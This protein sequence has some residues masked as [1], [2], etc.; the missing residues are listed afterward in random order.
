MMQS[1]LHQYIILLFLLPALAFPTAT[2]DD[3]IPQPDDPI[4]FSAYPKFTSLRTCL[5]TLFGDPSGGGIDNQVAINV[6]CEAN[7]CLCTPENIAANLPHISSQVSE[8]CT[9]KKDVAVATSVLSGYCSRI[10][11]DLKTTTLGKDGYRSLNS[12]G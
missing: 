2:S 11:A 9:N 5:R 4:D 12:F 10:T 8:S 7:S 3:V 1:S 6:R